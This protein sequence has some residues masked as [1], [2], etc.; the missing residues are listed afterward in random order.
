MHRRHV[1]RLLLAGAATLTAC[2]D[3]G[4]SAAD[5]RADQL[6][7]AAAEAGLPDEVVAFLA[8]AA[9]GVDGTYRVTYEVAD[10][11][12]APTQRLTITQD[13]PNRRLDVDRDDGPD[14][15]TI[16]TPDGALQCERPAE[17]GA[18]SCEQVTNA[19]A[20]GVF[21]QDRV[22]ALTT[23]LTDAAGSYTFA[24]EERTVAAVPARC[25]VATRRPEVDDPTLG[26]TATLCVSPEGAQLL[27]EVATGTLRAI[28][29]STDVPAD[30]FD[31]PDTTP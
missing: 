13:P 31:R 30:A 29:Y 7:G 22:E 25:L 14:T 10:P 19:S 4:P 11:A 26:A 2:G 6:E 8:T 12:G 20:E 15:T 17:D 18:W 3:D 28:E 1:A 21:A 16:G 5:Q 23:A 9:A 24:I 27:T